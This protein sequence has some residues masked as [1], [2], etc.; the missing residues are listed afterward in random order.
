[1]CVCTLSVA[2]S[3]HTQPSAQFYSPALRCA[4]RSIVRHV[5]VSTIARAKCV[6]VLLAK[7]VCVHPFSC[8]VAVCTAR[9]AEQPVLQ[10]LETLQKVC[11]LVAFSTAH[12]Q[13]I[14][15]PPSPACVVRSIVQ[16]LPS[17]AAQRAALHQARTA[18][19]I[20]Q[21]P[22]LHCTAKTRPIAASPAQR[23]ALH[24]AQHYTAPS[25]ASHV[26]VSTIA[27]AK[28]VCVLLAKC[29]CA[30]FQLLGRRKH[31]ASSTTTAR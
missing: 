21:R 15:Q 25:T 14:I 10:R 2:G 18:R 6:C 19:S 24:S 28:C 29:V 8:C 4:V 17:S 9:A 22:T 7:C 16:P 12:I 5:T 13:K 11:A 26:T 30:P 20:A 23:V 3:L 27:R 31:R 1:M